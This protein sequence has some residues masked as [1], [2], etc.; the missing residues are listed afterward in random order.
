M[1]NR[2]QFAIGAG[3]SAAA[4]TAA[5]GS[6]ALAVAPTRA[7]AATAKALA[8]DPPA[9]TRQ[10]ARWIVSTV[11]QD[12]PRTARDEA[13]RSIFNWVGCCLGGARQTTTD[14]A[15]AALAEFSGPA[16]ATVLGRVERLDILHAA[17]MNGISSHVLDYDDTHLATII[18]PAG[19]VAASIL[20]L[21][22]RLGTSGEEF[23]HA[24][25]L[26]VEAECRIGLAVY[27]SH[28][29]RGFHITGTAG[30]FGSAVAAGKLLQLNE[31][32][33]IW[34]LGIAATQAAGLKEMFGT[35]CK[36][37]HPGNAAQNG[38]KAA[39]LAAKNYTSSDIALEAPEGFLF[40]Y[41][42]E[43]DFAQITDGLGGRWEIEK[44]TYKP[45]SCGIV[46]HPIIDG[47]LQLRSEY[48]LRPEMISRVSLRVN[49]LVIKLTG[50]KTP[51]TGLEAKFSIFYISAAAL[52]HGAAGPNQFTDAAVRE[53]ITVALRDRVEATVD[54]AVSEEEAFVTI[55]LNDGRVL[56]KHIEHAI[57]SVQRP[58]TKAQ[59][60]FKFSDQAATALPATQVD[61]VMALCWHLEHLATINE[62]A[63]AT[64]PDALG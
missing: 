7:S 4:G 49:P 60:E 15:L 29:E 25:I 3:A 54:A 24:F 27:P 26:G 41:S 35:M 58:L 18:H 64:V 36:A 28:Y 11:W 40:S 23:L 32:Q 2:R 46:T 51:Q 17:L 12:V 21:G 33:M 30:V 53:A 13:L 34:A 19:P 42:D 1:L 55:T 56:E 20:A 57:G 8:S 48:A 39:L 52:V 38:L 5:L 59:L 22:Q 31:Q 47:C 50:K 37:L 16:E 43:Q 10:L 9:S 61:R 44:N 14:R 6:I 62:I 63:V 45:F